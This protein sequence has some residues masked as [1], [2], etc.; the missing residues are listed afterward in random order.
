MAV[1]CGARHHGPYAARVIWSDDAALLR[2][3][4]RRYAALGATGAESASWRTAGL[5]VGRV[6]LTLGLFVSI[7]TTGRLV[8]AQVAGTMIAWAFTPLVQTIAVLVVARIFAP[9]LARSRVLDLYFAGH[10]PWLLLMW[11][12]AGI[13]VVPPTPTEI[14]FFLLRHGIAPGLLVGAFVWGGLLNVAMFRSGLGL[15]RAKTALATS[16]FYVLFVGEVVAYYLVS[17]AIQPQLG[18]K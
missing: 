4:F 3:P 14:F 2:H 13:V 9:D 16:L 1:V 8:P 11:I 5:R 17:D 15:S 12:T 7:T 18:V 6:M 10:G